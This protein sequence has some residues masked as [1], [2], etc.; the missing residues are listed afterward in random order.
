MH[1]CKL[2]PLSLS[3][4]AVPWGPTNRIASNPAVFKAGET[5]FVCVADVMDAMTSHRPYRPAISLQE[6]MDSLSR[7]AGK[8]YNSEAVAACIELF[9]EGFQIKK[10]VK[11]A[12][13]VLNSLAPGVVLKVS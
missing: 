11:I 1:I 3:F 6:A 4:P 5:G 10:R 2:D 9:R 13:Q 7:K 8:W 12:N